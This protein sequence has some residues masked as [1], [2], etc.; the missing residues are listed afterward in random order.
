[1]AMD[2]RRQQRQ[3]EILLRVDE[4]AER[5]AI[6]PATLRARILKREIPFVRVGR[7]VRIKVSTIDALIA[8][9]EVAVR[10]SA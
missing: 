7:S 3:Q 8:D 4:A 2:T 5:L 6:K 1:M 10:R 9:G